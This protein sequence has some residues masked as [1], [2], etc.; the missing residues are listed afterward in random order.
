MYAP[1]YIFSSCFSI[2]SALT[3]TQIST[4]EKEVVT[5]LEE[6][7]RLYD[8]P[9]SAFTA[10]KRCRPAY[11][12]Y[13]TL[14]FLNKYIDAKLMEQANEYTLLSETL[15]LE[16]PK[17][18]SLTSKLGN[19]CLARFAAIQGDW[20][21][22]WTKK[23]KAYLAVDLLETPKDMTS[24]TKEFTSN[25]KAALRMIEELSIVHG[26]PPKDRSQKPLSPTSLTSKPETL[27]SGRPSP[28]TT[29]HKS[30]ESEKE[31]KRRSGSP[32]PDSGAQSSSRPYSGVFQ[33]ASPLP[34]QDGGPENLQQPRESVERGQFE[35]G[36]YNVLYQA[37][38]L[39]EFNISATKTEAGYPYLT[40]QAGEVSTYLFSIYPAVAYL[41]TLDLRC[42]WRESRAR[43]V[44]RKESR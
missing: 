13:T 41:L 26:S 20:W 12:K 43:A 38:S 6:A 5:P 32:K 22:T 27:S 15:D 25:H 31:M 2:R 7:L 44:A 8:S 30:W 39:F 40:Y 17:L 35:S 16:L 14:K 10:L 19:E 1:L 9:G 29:S 34:N 18:K 42:N 11:E 33:Y 28:S 21:N 24:I 4:I 36:G 23:L 37:A 3:S